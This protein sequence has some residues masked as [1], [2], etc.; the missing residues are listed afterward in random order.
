VK[1]LVEFITVPR[2]GEKANGDA[3]LVR[4]WDGGV[5][6]A[7]IDSLGHGEHAAQATAVGLGYLQGVSV[8]GGLRPVVD[9]LHERLRGTRG[10]AAMLLLMDEQRL[11]GCGVGNVALRSYRARVPAMLSP[12]ILGASLSRVH[13]FTAELAPGDRLVVFSDG[14]TARFDDEASRRASA[15]ETCRV[16]MERYRRP[17]DDATVL[18][19]DIEGDTKG[20][21]SPNGRHDGGSAPKPRAEG[22]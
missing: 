13:V 7:V 9:G 8:K 1:A 17:H 6:V 5:L 3:A 10:A 16:I 21:P 19:I 4:R 12:G 11:E 15:I 14:I 20:A 22:S 2:E 18:V